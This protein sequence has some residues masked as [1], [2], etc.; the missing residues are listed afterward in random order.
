MK[1][2]EILTPELYAQV[3]AQI[4][5]HNAGE[6]DKTKHVRFADLSEGNYVS[7]E[8]Y[9]AQIEARDNQIT[10]LNEQITQ[11]DADIT[12]LNEQL[13]AAQ[14]DAS[15]LG[16]AQATI[17]SLQSK[18]EKDKQNWQEASAKQQRSFAVREKAGTLKFTSAAAKRDFLNAANAKDFKLEGETLTGYDDFLNGYKAENPDAFVVEKPAEPAPTPAPADNGGK[19]NPVI[20]LPGNSGTQ[21]K[22]KSLS[23]LMKAK[24]ENPDMIVSFDKK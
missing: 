13:T 21:P 4:D 22:G 6:A 14:A 3:K 24:N 10:G 9:N 8:K 20:V 16:E 15:K 7:V 12:S 1:L 23:E 11:R 17:T 19:K 5:A 2:S 18:Y